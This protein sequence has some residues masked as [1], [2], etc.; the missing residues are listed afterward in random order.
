MLIILLRHDLF[1]L[2]I[3]QLHDIVCGYRI[4]AVM[5]FVNTIPVDTGHNWYS[6]KKTMNHQVHA[7]TTDP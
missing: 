5:D 6:T 2:I 4:W 7:H 3:H 1:F